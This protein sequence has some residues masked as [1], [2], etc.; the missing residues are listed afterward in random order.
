MLG[1]AVHDPTGLEGRPG[2]S[3]G[4]SLL[5][6]ETT[7]KAPK[8]TTLT[9]FSWNEQHGAGYEIHMGQTVRT[10]GSPLYEISKRNHN[11]CRD[12]DGCVSADSKTMGTYIHGLFD[13]PGILK[14]WLNHIGLRDVDV[15]DVGGIDAR[16]REY[17]LLAAHFEKHI[18]VESIVNLFT[19]RG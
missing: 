3:E 11:A 1:N 13:N 17:D 16:N 6:I 7:L 4:L 10:G 5:P 14:Q 8:T 2:S 19:N 15:S 18:D 12:E 9:Q